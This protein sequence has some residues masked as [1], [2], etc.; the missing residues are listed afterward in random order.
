MC[1]ATVV[2]APC[3]RLLAPLPPSDHTTDLADSHECCFRGF[4]Q[5]AGPPGPAA[6]RQFF[7][8]GGVA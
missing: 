2:A 1:G 8:C 7:L 4:G 5:R 6:G 3:T